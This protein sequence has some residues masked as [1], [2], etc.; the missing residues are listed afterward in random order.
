MKILLL[1]GHSA[2]GKTT[3]AEAIA[4]K[5]DCTLLLERAIIDAV[6]ER[7]GFCRAR[8]CIKEMGMEQILEETREETKKE[9]LNAQNGKIIID[10]VYDGGLV[11]FLK[12]N[13]NGVE[14]LVVGVSSNRTMRKHRF[15][16]RKGWPMRES[17]KE[18]RIIDGIK[19]RAGTYNIAK[20]PDIKIKNK[21]RFADFLL[22]LENVANSFFNNG[23]SK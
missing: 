2:V 17:L 14:L 4:K 16:K 9:I 12:E 10:G 3:A 22:E 8:D 19:D 1:A 11:K 18:L 13:L 20:S 7:K 6:I 21:G 15:M 5:M 23:A